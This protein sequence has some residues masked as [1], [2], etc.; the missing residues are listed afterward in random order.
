LSFQRINDT[1]PILKML[2]ERMS[3]CSQ[4]KMLKMPYTWEIHLKMKRFRDALREVRDVSWAHQGKQ[5]TFYL[6]GMFSYNGLRGAY[7]GISITGSHCALMCDHCKASTL[8]PMPAAGSADALVAMCKRFATKGGLGVL[9][10]GGSDQA[11]RLPWRTFVPAIE[12]IKETTDLYVS[13]HCGLLDLD[14]ARSLKEAGVDQALLDVVGD[15]ET[16]QSVCHVDFGISRIISTL[17]VLN[18]VELP[19]IPHVIC[20]LKRGQMGSE[21]EALDII[22]RFRIEQLVVVSL[23]AIKETP[24]EGVIT[25][26]AREVAGII[27]E[28]RRRMPEVRMSLGCARTRGDE[29]VELLALEAGVNR[30]ALPSDTVIERARKFGLEI[31][32]QRTCC[33]VGADFSTPCW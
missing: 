13:I 5:I 3:R 12:K 23:M 25:P 17:D 2:G 19:V 24:F 32:Y 18:Q 21:T 1:F 28:A 8:K 7:P 27:V 15:D 20:G 29:E 33:S 30:M 10:S 9:I 11:G 22:S 16:Y 31:R 6:P 14:T 4:K 26:S